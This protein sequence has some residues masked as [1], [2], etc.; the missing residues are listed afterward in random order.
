M[1]DA[2]YLVMFN[3][4][5]RRGKELYQNDGDIIKTTTGFQIIFTTNVTPKDLDNKHPDKLSIVVYR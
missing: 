2:D 5:G 1:I 4:H 3:A